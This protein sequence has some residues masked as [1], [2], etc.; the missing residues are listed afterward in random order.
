MDSSPVR[1]R[2][3]VRGRGRGRVG[4]RGRVR[5]G[6]LAIRID[7]REAELILTEYLGRVRIGVMVHTLA[8]TLAEEGTYLTS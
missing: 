5:V 4:I 7:D 8:L 6:L 1:V 3:T 2:V